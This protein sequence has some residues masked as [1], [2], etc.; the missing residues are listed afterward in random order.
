MV[1]ETK[2]K[3]KKT[4]KKAKVNIKKKEVVISNSHKKLLKS[5]NIEV[6]NTGRDV[7]AD[8]LNIP[9]GPKVK[10]VIK[11]PTEK[12]GKGLDAAIKGHNAKTRKTK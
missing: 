10:N 1:V 12:V 8:I 11:P 4:K 3:A 6:T 9:A 5:K 2:L 7:L